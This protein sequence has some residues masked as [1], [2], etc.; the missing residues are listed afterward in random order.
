VNY[1]GKL[2]DGTVFDSSYEKEAFTVPIGEGNVIKGWDIGIM[3]MKLGEKVELKC[4][5]E[6]GYGKE[7]SPPTIPADSTL[8]YTLELLMCGGRAS[9]EMLKWKDTAKDF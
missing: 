5:P 1:E 9:S 8:I 4:S 7:G 3:S 2:M 6:Y